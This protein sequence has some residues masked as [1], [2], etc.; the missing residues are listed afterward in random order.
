MC[1]YAGGGGGLSLTN[2]K[3]RLAT[4]AGVWGSRCAGEKGK[5]KRMLSS[6]AL[7]CVVFLS[8]RSDART[9]GM[10]N[11]QYGCEVLKGEVR[12]QCP[13]PGLQLA[14]DGRTCV[15]RSLIYPPPPQAGHLSLMLPFPPVSNWCKTHARMLFL[16]CCSQPQQL[17]SDH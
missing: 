9:C 2:I 13:S 7:I 15:G 11:C 6:Q 16:L 14:A 17:T 10:A 1:C 3:E 8:R 4:L 12:C 5:K